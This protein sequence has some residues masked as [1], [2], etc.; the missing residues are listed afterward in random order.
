[1]Q[2]V[3]WIVY[4]MR[5]SAACTLYSR[6]NAFP[7]GNLEGVYW[8]K[9]RSLEPGFTAILVALRHVCDIDCTAMTTD[10]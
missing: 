3:L 2:L 10:R 1:M 7:A 6:N 9:L 8:P 5:K 4:T